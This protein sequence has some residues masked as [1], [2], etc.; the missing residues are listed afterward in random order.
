MLLALEH[1]LTYPLLL[2]FCPFLAKKKASQDRI[3]NIFNP[4]GRLCRY[5][6]P[7]NQIFLELLR[8]SFTALTAIDMPKLV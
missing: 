5:G 2:S 6:S 1:R 4:V 7:V 3:R 8:W